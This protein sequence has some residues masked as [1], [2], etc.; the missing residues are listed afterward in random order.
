[1]VISHFGKLDLLSAP[2]GPLPAIHP[3]NTPRALPVARATARVRGA[4]G[5][6]AHLPRTMSASSEGAGC[7]R[8]VRG[9]SD[10]VGCFGPKHESA[11]L[12]GDRRA[13]VDLAAR[14]STPAPSPAYR[15]SPRSEDDDS[16]DDRGVSGAE[17]GGVTKPARGFAA[18]P[19]VHPA[20]DP[21]H[22]PSLLDDAA[23]PTPPDASPPSPLPSLALVLALAL[24]CFGV[25]LAVGYP[26]AAAPT[27]LCA[28]R[29]ARYPGCVDDARLLL[30]ENLLYL[31]AALGAALGSWICDLAGRRG[32]LRVASA[33]ASAGWG[34]SAA[35]GFAGRGGVVGRVVVGVASGVVSVAAPILASESSS[36]RSRGSAHAG[37]QLAFAAGLM[38]QCAAGRMG[39]E[40]PHWRAGAFAAG[41]C[42]AT[43]WAA[44]SAAPESP[45]W[46]IARGLERKAARAVADARGWA[47]DDPRAAAETSTAA[48][49]LRTAPPRASS[50][51]AP[52]ILTGTFPFRALLTQRYLSR[53]LLAVTAL[54]ATQQLGGLSLPYRAATTAEVSGFDDAPSAAAAAAAARLAGCLLCAWTLRDGGAG[55]RFAFLA[56]LVGMAI[57]NVAVVMSSTPAAAAAADPE[58]RDATRALAPLLFTFAHAAGVGTVPWLVAT[59]AFPHYARAAAVAFVGAAHWSYALDVSA[60]FRSAAGGSEAGGVTAF[61][62][63]GLV[64]AVGVSLVAPRG[65][66]AVPEGDGLELEE[67]YSRFYLKEVPP[68]ASLPPRVPGL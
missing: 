54:T 32:A 35:F 30:L 47:G 63:F 44:A 65:Q 10:G 48:N 2:R 17:M 27:L 29:G 42:A 57:A 8:G 20:Y 52:S 67:V 21:Y 45:R 58:T 12:L 19:D 31:F 38:A 64:C 68:L 14:G 62:A 50:A 37:C 66:E 13:R 7:F 40:A 25:G 33:C 16:S 26:R 49:R 4:K 60:G 11:P 39:T 36:A 51:A 6:R 9:G 59:E 46:L 43:A 28:D 5:A 15:P 22:L 34:V 18:D 1:M 24:A 61:G 41:A 55:R 53:R 56:S 23:A 3:R